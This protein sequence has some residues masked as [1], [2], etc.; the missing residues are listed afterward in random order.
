MGPTTGISSLDN[1]SNKTKILKK[2]SEPIK[3]SENV[4]SVLWSPEEDLYSLK[5]LNLKDMNRKNLKNCLEEEMSYALEIVTIMLKRKM[6][7][8]ILKINTSI[9]LSFIK[10]PN[11][12]LKVKKN[13]NS[14]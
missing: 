12:T 6:P 14:E 1:S 11:L 13:S 5:L 3:I 8:K 2:F 7:R 10:N 4:G 9:E